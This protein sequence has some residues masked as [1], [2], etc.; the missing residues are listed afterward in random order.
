MGASIARE[1][2]VLIGL[3]IGGSRFLGTRIADPG[4][5]GAIRKKPIQLSLE[6]G[7]ICVGVR[8]HTP[9]GSTPSW[10]P[11]PAVAHLAVGP[12]EMIRSAQR[13]GCSVSIAALV[14][15]EARP[16]GLTAD[17]ELAVCFPFNDPVTID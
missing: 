5:S 4:R 2:F 8:T 1:R 16:M 13:R 10:S 6:S 15:K 12:C 17:D 11:C 14:G 9:V 3:G 7:R